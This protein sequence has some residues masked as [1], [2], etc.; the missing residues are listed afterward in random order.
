MVLVSGNN[1]ADALSATNIV[2]SKSAYIMLAPN[3]IKR[4]LEG[5]TTKID[6]VF[7]VGGVNSVSDREASDTINMI[8]G[9][10]T[11]EVMIVINNPK[12]STSEEKLNITIKNNSKSTIIFGTGYD[13]LYKVL[14]NGKL[15][16]IYI[17]GIGNNGVAITLEPKK[18][19]SMDIYYHPDMYDYKKGEYVLEKEISI[20]G[21]IVPIQDR[22]VIE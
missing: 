13:R 8:N 14:G 12:I 6:N 17:E 15:E 9:T 19:H 4:E 16:G 11:E 1:F 3:S 2:N 18:E 5:L 22:F 20:N 10:Y 21:K 7:V